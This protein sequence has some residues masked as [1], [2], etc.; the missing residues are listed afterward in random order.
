MGDDNITISTA[1][2]LRIAAGDRES[3]NHVTTRELGLK[4]IFRRSSVV[5][6]TSG[7]VYLL[8]GINTSRQVLLGFPIDE[9]KALS[10]YGHRDP[11]WS[12]CIEDS[13]VTDNPPEDIPAADVTAAWNFI[14]D[15]PTRNAGDTHISESAEVMSVDGWV[16]PA[17][18]GD[19]V[20]IILDL[21]RYDN[22]DKNSPWVIVYV[23]SEK[24][25]WGMLTLGVVLDAHGDTTHKVGNMLSIEEVLADEEGWNICICDLT[26][27]E[28]EE[29]VR[30]AD[31]YARIVAACF[32]YIE[33]VE[34]APSP[35]ELADVKAVPQDVLQQVLDNI[36]GMNEITF[37]N[38]AVEC[39][40]IPYTKLH[41]Y[42]EKVHKWAHI[43]QVPNGYRK[44][45]PFDVICD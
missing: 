43:M 42:S 5:A 40:A 16:R 14:S 36:D 32:G 27:A 17:R 12:H 4:D 6:D 25:G 34:L 29:M 20:K 23:T 10:K 19:V 41:V 26:N 28:H 3:L 8:D 13:T 1:E 18:R 39:I 21:E 45:D 22:G 24:R 11:I 44:I 9:Q 7:R 15:M 37:S 2:L 33:Y 30:R 31:E 38:G 35:T